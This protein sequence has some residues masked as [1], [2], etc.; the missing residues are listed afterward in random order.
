M[1]TCWTT[2]YYDAGMWIANIGMGVLFAIGAMVQWND[3]DPLGW[4]LVYMAAAIACGTF[5]RFSWAWLLA[6][7]TAIV[8]ISWGAWIVADMPRWVTPSQMFEPMQSR[9]GA[10]ELARE[11]WGLGIIALWML[12][13]V[14]A[15]RK[16]VS[17]DD[18]AL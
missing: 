15:G 8:A 4:I 11:A 18:A 7:V 3:P 9:G 13:L 12:L 2:L 17:V 5:R 1:A 14:W 10:V 16:E 6:L